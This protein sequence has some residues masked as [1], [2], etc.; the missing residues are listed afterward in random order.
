MEEWKYI[1][2]ILNLG[3]S[4]RCVVS[5][6]PRPIYLRIKSPRHPLDR[7]LLYDVEHEISN[8]VL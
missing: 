3:T 7:R 6:T 5:L 8:D 1:S 2:N 4:R